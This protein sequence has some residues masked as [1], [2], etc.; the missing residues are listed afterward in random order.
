M[1]KRAAFFFLETHSIVEMVDKPPNKNL[2][3]CRYE[4]VLVILSKK[5]DDPKKLPRIV[6]KELKDLVD[7]NEPEAKGMFNSDEKNKCSQKYLELFPIIV[8]IC[9]ILIA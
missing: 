2:F 9:I 3:V 7:R 5:T 8:F 6:C 1:Q 4:L